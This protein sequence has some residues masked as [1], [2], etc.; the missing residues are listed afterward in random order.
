MN[1]T[2][3]PNDVKKGER[4]LVDDGKLL[5]E[6]L[7]TNGVDEVK[8]KVIQGGILSS[9]KGVNLPNT[10]LSLPALTI[11]IKKMLFLL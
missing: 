7:N 6:I 2:D 4:I 8:A 3:F 11:K 1:Y 5:F 10:K 9:K